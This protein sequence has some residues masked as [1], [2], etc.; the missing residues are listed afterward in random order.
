MIIFKLPAKKHALVVSALEGAKGRALLDAI[1][2]NIVLNSE[3]SA[4]AR[5]GAGEVLKF[6]RSCANDS[7]NI[8]HS[9]TDKP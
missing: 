6:L 9:Q 3:L 7:D 5:T 2:D 4:E 1:T 8:I